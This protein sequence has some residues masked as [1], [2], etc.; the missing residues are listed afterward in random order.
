MQCQ[1]LLQQ[2][3]ISIKLYA[4]S[5]ACD[6]TIGCSW[7]SRLGADAEVV[8]IQPIQSRGH[9]GKLEAKL[10]AGYLAQSRTF[11]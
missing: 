3:T 6:R 1:K 2:C 9:G 4:C 8:K 5:N 10:L 7:S 11:C